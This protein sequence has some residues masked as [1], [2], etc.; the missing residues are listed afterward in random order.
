LKPAAAEKFGAWTG[1][2][3]NKYLGVVLN[4]EVRSIAYIKSQ[5]SD[6]G[7]IS[8]RFTKQ[9][10]ED[11]ALILRSGALTAPVKIVEEGAKK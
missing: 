9:A 5:I 8:G 11:M 2:H 6:H 7:E 1:A 3:I 4:G 10:A